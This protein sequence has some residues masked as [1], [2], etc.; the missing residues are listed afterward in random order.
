MNV[1]AQLWATRSLK[2]HDHGLTTMYTY[3]VV[4]RIHFVSKKPH[5]FDLIHA[6][7]YSEANCFFCGGILRARTREHVFPK[8]LQERFRLRHKTLTLLNGTDIQYSK[9]TVPCCKRCNT[10]HLSRL[11]NKVKRLLFGK[12][13][14]EPRLH[15]D[16][17]LT[18]ASKILLGIV[19][20]ERLLPLDR[21]DPQRGV[22]WPVEFKHSFQMTH[23]LV[24]SL[25]MPITFEAEGSARIPGSV[26]VFDLQAPP[27]V[28]HQFDFR[29]DINTLSI[30]MRLGTRGIIAVTDGGAVDIEIGGR[31]RRDARRKLHPIQFEELGSKAFYKASLLNRTPKYI[32]T[33][34]RRKYHIMQMP[35][36]GLSAKPVFDEWHQA[37]YAEFLA[38]F[39]GSPVDSIALGDRSRVTTWLRDLEGN[40]IYLRLKP[41]GETVRRKPRLRRTRVISAHA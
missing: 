19:Y 22:I 17:M 3:D 6:R 37:K 28:D 39:T 5:P 40:P 32:M 10:V 21:R 41:N 33:Y 29:D 16:L 31:I 14:S 8:W 9:L 20:A 18:W 11:E 12:P 15:S 30:F 38:S 4:L 35:L 13:I 1:P 26:F 2:E 23:F 36:A 7:E 25:H 34:N 24:Q 27:D